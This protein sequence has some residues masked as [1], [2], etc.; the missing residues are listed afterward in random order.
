M[1]L[2]ASGSRHRWLQITGG[3]VFVIFLLVI[4]QVT[5]PYRD[6]ALVGVWV[7]TRAGMP[8]WKFN[9]DIEPSGGL[10]IASYMPEGRQIMSVRYEWWVDDDRLVIQQ[11][12]PA[13]GW[14][15]VIRRL[16]QLR[17]ELAGRP[18]SSPREIYSIRDRSPDGFTLQSIAGGAELTFIRRA[19]RSAPARNAL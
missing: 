6:P 3:M 13:A 17:D 19:A 5:L 12:A 10:R 15:R 4:W 14:Q 16:K 11:E 2:F 9:Y 8:D 1:K 18:V 7:A